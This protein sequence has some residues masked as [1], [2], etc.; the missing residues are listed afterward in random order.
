[1]RKSMIFTASVQQD[2]KRIKC[3]KKITKGQMPPAAMLLLVKNW[4]HGFLVPLKITKGQTPSQAM[5]LLVKNRGTFFLIF[6]KTIKGW[7]PSRAMLLREHFSRIFK[8]ESKP[9][10]TIC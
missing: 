8:K 6:K 2:L 4:S 1:M 5:L 9:L 3:P 7:M 10:C